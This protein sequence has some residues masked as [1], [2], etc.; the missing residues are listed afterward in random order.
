MMRN[1]LIIRPDGDIEHG[2]MDVSYPNINRTLGVQWIEAISTAGHTFYLDE[3]GKINRLPQNVLAEALFRG[4]GGYLGSDFL[5][6][7]VCIVGGPD[8]NGDDTD[9]NPELIEVAQS[10]AANMDDLIAEDSE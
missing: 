5:V 1:A 4:L 7:P 3:E 10:L 9:I 6:G 2:P 8:G